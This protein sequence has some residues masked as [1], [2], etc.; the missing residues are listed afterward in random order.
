MTSAIAPLVSLHNR[1]RQALSR[2][3]GFFCCFKDPWDS[4]GQD[5]VISVFHLNKKYVFVND[6]FHKNITNNY[7]FWSLFYLQV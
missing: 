2:C 7:Y 3:S 1:L 4:N 6:I 5:F